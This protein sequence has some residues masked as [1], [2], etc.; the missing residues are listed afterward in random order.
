MQLKE[1]ASFHFLISTGSILL[2]EFDELRIMFK[3]LQEEWIKDPLKKPV[4]YSPFELLILL[5]SA[6]N[7][8]SLNVTGNNIRFVWN[9]A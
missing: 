9:I 7:I 8:S 5:N 4:K 6:A 2:Q 3:E 1:S